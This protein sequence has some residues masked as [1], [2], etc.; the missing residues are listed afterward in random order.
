MD[1]T[2]RILAC[3]ALLGSAIL[4]GCNKNNF[5]ANKGEAV[6]FSAVSQGAPSTKT[7]YGQDSGNYQIID[8]SANDLI[9]VYSDKAVHRYDD[10]QNWA[11]YIILGSTVSGHTSTASLAAK[12]L[13]NTDTDNAAGMSNGLI[14]GSA[15]TYNFWG[16]FP[17]TA[18]NADITIGANGTVSASLPVSTALSGTSSTKYVDATGKIVDAAVDGGYAYKVYEP[19]MNYAYMTSVASGVEDGASFNLEFTPAFTAF[20]INL[21][22]ADD[23]ADGF[24]VSGISLA[25]TD[26]Y[27]AG[28]FTMTAGDLTTVTAASSASKSVAVTAE[29]PIAIDQTNG[30]SVTLFAIPKANSGLISLLVETDKGPATLRLLDN[31]KKAP[32]EFQPG[33][34]YRIN[35]LKIGGRWTYM[36]SL[37]SEA[38]EWDLEEKETNFMQNI[39]AEAFSIAGHT[40]GDANNYYPDNVSRT[41]NI[42]TLDMNVPNP[43]FE[44]TFTPKSPRGGYWMLTPISEAGLGTSAFR[45]VVVEID[46]ETESEDLRGSIMSKEVTLRIYPTITDAQRTEDHAISFL[47]FFSNSISFDD[48]STFSADSEIQDAHGDGTFSYWR[49]VIPEKIN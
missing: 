44:V 13:D 32:Y 14:W 17:S 47:C 42:R 35:L 43:H 19:D 11:D 37:S 27:L 10:K 21:T 7:T 22:S 5:V 39:E 49:F 45:V 29:T 16:I 33:K 3:A 25:S 1:K 36:I 15:E 26:D 40:E 31:T 4:T 2:I 23:E 18:Q 28:P 41:Y 6:R 46:G 48:N 12:T 30:L 38:I 34:K 8:W 9:R 24:T 20:E